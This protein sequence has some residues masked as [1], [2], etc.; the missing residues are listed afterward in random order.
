MAMPDSQLCWNVSE[1]DHFE[2]GL[3]TSGFLSEFSSTVKN[4]D[5]DMDIYPPN[6]FRGVTYV[7]RKYV[8]QSRALAE[9][10]DDCE[11]VTSA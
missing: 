4:H 3:M 11:G 6:N 7:I 1:W 9:F 5:M 2:E 10:R 8:W